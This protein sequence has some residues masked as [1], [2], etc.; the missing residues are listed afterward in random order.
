LDS[1]SRIW[2]LD[3]ADGTVRWR[4]EADFNLSPAVAG[5]LV[6]LGR[7]ALDAATGRVVWEAEDLD[8]L[9][10]PALAGDVVYGVDSD[11]RVFA[12]DAAAGV[13]HWQKELREDVSLWVTTLAVGGESIHFCRSSGGDLV[14]LDITSGEERWYVGKCASVSGVPVIAAEKLLLAGGTVACWGSTGTPARRSG[15]W[16]RNHRL[17]RWPTT[18]CTR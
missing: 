4:A 15:G 9:S 13:V 8:G 16:R 6:H 3:A 1:T 7:S 10:S 11:G 12:L 14:E 5:G 17:R 2:A 18:W